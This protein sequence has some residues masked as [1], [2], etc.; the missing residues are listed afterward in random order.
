MFCPPCLFCGAGYCRLLAFFGVL[1]QFYCLGRFVRLVCCVVRF[2]SGVVAAF[3]AV[4]AAFAVSTA[5]G[6]CAG[7]VWSLASSVPLYQS[8]LQS[9]CDSCYFC[10]LAFSTHLR[11]TISRIVP[12]TMP[13]SV[14]DAH[15]LA[16][17]K[18]NSVQACIRISET[19]FVETPTKM[20]LDCIAVE[21]L[22]PIVLKQGGC[23]GENLKPFS[24]NGN[25][26]GKKEGYTKELLPQC[27]HQHKARLVSHGG[28]DTAFEKVL[29]Y[30]LKNLPE[31][32]WMLMRKRIIKTLK[33]KSRSMFLRE[34][35]LMPIIWQ[36]LV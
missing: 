25:K 13:N 28:L 24:F 1:R 21:T 34:K 27:V 33:D 30:F 16:I 15:P 18:P 14:V 26:N 6:F 19:I 12:H 29:D 9:C 3:L 5:L 10:S 8:T 7:L 22:S 36:L 17:V 23:T 2:L 20:I 4:A 11:H 35:Q 31:R 32:N